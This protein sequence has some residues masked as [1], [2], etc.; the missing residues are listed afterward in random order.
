MT[1][2]DNGPWREWR[3]R[4]VALDF[5]GVHWIGQA[6]ADEIFRVFA[7]AHP[8]VELMPVHADPEVQQMIRRAE[9]ARDLDDGQLPSA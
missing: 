7:R 8:E 5:A 3:F 2:K 4:H 9:V 6:F 1:G